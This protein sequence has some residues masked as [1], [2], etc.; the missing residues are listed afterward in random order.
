MRIKRYERA[1]KE[2]W[3]NF[4]VQ[5]KN[6]TFLFMRDYMDYHADRFQDFSLIVYHD[7]GELAALLPANRKSHAC[8][9]HGGLSYGGFITDRTMKLPRMI[10]VFETTL[11]YLREENFRELHYTTVPSI[12]ARLPS[13]EDRYALF[14]CEARRTR[15]SAL[16]VLPRAADVTWQERRKRGAKKAAQSGLVVRRSEDWEA[17]WEILCELLHEAHAGA[18]VHSVSEIKLL[19]SRF[20]HNIRLHGAFRQSEMLA[21]IVIYETPLVART[22]YIAANPEGRRLGAIDL[23]MQELL[24][25]VYEEKAYIDFGSSEAENGRSVNLGLID[26]KEGYGARIVAHDHYYLDLQAADL[27]KLSGALQ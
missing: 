18:P 6:G 22:Q 10:E 25:H 19:Q 4:V 27:T 12:Y 5:S 7:S 26:Q 8:F 15:S 14:L 13:E 20:P 23:I 17:Y 16:A 3:D 1:D 9:S 24:A 2:L 21:G 11:R